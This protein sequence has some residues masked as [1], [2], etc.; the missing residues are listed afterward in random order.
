MG[1]GGGAKESLNEFGLPDLMD[2]EIT[3]N[4][5]TTSKKMNNLY[6]IGTNFNSKENSR[7]Q[8]SDLRKI[9]IKTQPNNK[10]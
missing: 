10:K 4:F 8:E 3:S 5:D 1:Q 2:V 6:Q 9:K 7:N